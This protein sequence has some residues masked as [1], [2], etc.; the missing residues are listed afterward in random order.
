MFSPKELDV[1]L[2]L[3]AKHRSGDWDAIQAPLDRSHP[4]LDLDTLSGALDL[5]GRII[6]GTVW[7]RWAVA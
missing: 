1:C 5:A 2:L 3:L 4:D 7:T 6:D